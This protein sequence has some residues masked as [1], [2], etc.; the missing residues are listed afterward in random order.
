MTD[1]APKGALHAIRA[2]INALSDSERRVAAFVTTHQAEAVTMSM[3]QVAHG[4][5]VSDAT[6]LRFAR[7]L[8]YDG[9]N[10]FKIALA[11]ELLSPGEETFEVVEPTDSHERVISK[12]ISTNVQ[13]LQD[14][15]QTLDAEQLRL[16]VD[17]LHRAHRIYV[18]AAGTSLPV[19]DWFYDRLFRLG[20][21]VVAI[22]DP[23][24]QQVQAAICEAGDVVVSISRSGAPKHLAEALR[25]LHRTAPQVCRIAITSDPRS[26]VAELSD[27]RLI[28][29]AREIR[30]DVASSLV[31]FSTIVDIVYTCLELQDVDRTVSQQQ[32]AWQAIEPLR[33]HRGSADEPNRAEPG[34][35]TRR[36]PSRPT[37]PEPEL[38]GR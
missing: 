1:A 2:Q 21:P 36:R 28:G 20:L 23:Y 35:D 33:A 38:G 16:S 32:A 30:S 37:A 18:F 4:A 7:A 27:L 24:R 3:L 25:T 11:A 19:A 15:L 9:F 14:T 22:T 12:V 8:G 26:R 10:G 5:G 31:V 13:T 6:V 17:A 29:A 34:P